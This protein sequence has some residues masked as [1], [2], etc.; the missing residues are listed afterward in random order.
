M[1]AKVAPKED[2][3][4]TRKDIETI[5]ST[6][7]ERLNMKHW[8]I[9][10]V[11]DEKTDAD[12]SEA[13]ATAW[14]SK[15]YDEATFHFNPEFDSWDRQKANVVSVHELLHCLGRDV[16]SFWDAIEGQLHKDVD[17]VAM[18][19]FEHNLEGFIDRLAYRLVEIGGPV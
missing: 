2:P 4:L 19:I 12:T 8:T 11:W 16:E 10:V 5:V 9:T 17:S 6:W 3:P 1:G 15:S 14:R 13:H 18:K 7:Q